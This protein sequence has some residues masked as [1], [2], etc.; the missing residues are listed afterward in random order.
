MTSPTP[1]PR[2][3]RSGFTL[4]E[5][6]LAMLLLAMIIGMVFGTARTSLQ[7]G[8]N[9]IKSQNE[10]MLHQA[11]FDLLSGRFLSMPGNARLE[12]TSEDTGTHH[13]S[14]LTLQNVPMSFTWGGQE[15]I[16]KAVQL[17]TVK[18]RSNFLDIVLRYYEEEVLE[19]AES[20]FGSNVVAPQPFAEI[21]LLEDVRFF[22]WRVLDGRSM[23]WYYDWDL[24]GR[25]PLQAELVLAFGATGPE[26]RHV[27]WIPP[28][29]N[30][31]VVNRQMMQEAQQ[32]IGIPGDPTGSGNGRRPPT[33]EI[34]GVQLPPVNP[35]PNE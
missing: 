28:R 32:N 2:T 25:L 15:R 27:F 14:E 21:V 26:M 24:P 7:L 3:R 31:T 23:E 30:P 34:P 16:A 20:N 5:L 19:D 33:I 17:V 9:V 22:E 29:Q 13:L 10:E 1:S 18:R 35:Q 12:L 11:F 8:V 4:L 6:V